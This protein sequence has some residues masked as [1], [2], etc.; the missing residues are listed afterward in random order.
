MTIAEKEKLRI[1]YVNISFFMLCFMVVSIATM[2]FV[3]I[4]EKVISSVSTG[5]TGLAISFA[6]VISVH[7]GTAPKKAE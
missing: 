6:G 5:F 2:A 1:K 7:F 3:G 4:D